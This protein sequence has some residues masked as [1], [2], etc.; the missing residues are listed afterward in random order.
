MLEDQPVFMR[1]T[2]AACTVVKAKP[3]RM[4]VLLLLL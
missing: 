1:D 2:M 3:L 4:K